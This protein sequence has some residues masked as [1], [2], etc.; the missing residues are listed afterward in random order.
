MLDVVGYNRDRRGAIRLEVFQAR[1]IDPEL[2]ER[3]VFVNGDNGNVKGFDHAEQALLGLL[4]DDAGVVA[5]VG[6]RDVVL[7]AGLGGHG[8]LRPPVRP[9][10]GQGV[11][12][13]PPTQL[14]PE[15]FDRLH[16]INWQF[17]LQ[18]PDDYRE[19]TTWARCSRTSAR[20]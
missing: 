5:A 15:D 9:D 16:N 13:T 18:F 3:R 10:R 8:R 4:V 1:S 20:S 6:A 12:L 2:D 14:Q 11:L 19:G 17:T 7:A